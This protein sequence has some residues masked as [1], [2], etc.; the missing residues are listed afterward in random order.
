MGSDGFPLTEPAVGWIQDE[1]NRKGLISEQG[2]K[3]TAFY[4]LQKAYED[5]SIGKAD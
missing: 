2:K 1:F 4:T 3:K 5:K